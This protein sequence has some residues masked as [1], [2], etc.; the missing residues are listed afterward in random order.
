MELFLI[1]G[2]ILVVAYFIFGRKKKITSLLITFLTSRAKAADRGLSHDGFEKATAEFRAIEEAKHRAEEVQKKE[3]QSWLDAE[4]PRETGSTQC[5]CMKPSL[6]LRN[7]DIIRL[8]GDK[9]YGE[10]KLQVC[11]S[12]GSK[13]LLY[14]I[15]FESF[16]R[17]G[18]AYR[19]L[20]PASHT[21]EIDPDECYC[22]R[23][24]Y[25]GGIG[26]R[27]SKGRAAV[28]RPVEIKRSSSQDYVCSA[29]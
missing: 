18:R 1:L 27:H 15:E 4:I 7:N 19:G 24:Y 16:F 10:V 29:S 28:L 8:G 14:F 22:V 17:S 13:W 2:G 3:M 9:R 11:N 21:V 20:L 23:H 5:S 25:T 12:C 26:K 6:S